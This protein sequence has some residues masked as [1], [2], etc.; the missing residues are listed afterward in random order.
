MSNYSGHGEQLYEK[1]KKCIFSLLILSNPMRRM[2]VK[3]LPS[4]IMGQS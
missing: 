1:V 4:Y 3:V 2:I